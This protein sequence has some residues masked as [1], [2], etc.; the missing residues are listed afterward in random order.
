M[1]EAPKQA[2]HFAASLESGT[3][4]QGHLGGVDP[5]YAIFCNEGPIQLIGEQQGLKT[6]IVSLSN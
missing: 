4:E 6:E 1:A 3:A 5:H 2:I